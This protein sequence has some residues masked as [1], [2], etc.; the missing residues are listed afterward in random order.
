[1]ALNLFTKTYLA[2]QAAGSSTDDA[3]RFL[4][5]EADSGRAD[6]FVAE[7]KDRG[8]SELASRVDRV[9]SGKE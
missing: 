4:I 3:P 7:L 9:G 8:G 1:M 2:H 5:C 6:A